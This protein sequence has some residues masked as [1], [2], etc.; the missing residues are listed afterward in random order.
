MYAGAGKQRAASGAALTF[1]RAANGPGE[2]EEIET[3][4]SNNYG[5]F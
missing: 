1:K 3:R 5:L 4:L 2:S